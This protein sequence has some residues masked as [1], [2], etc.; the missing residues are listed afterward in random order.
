MLK[1][2]LEREA[3]ERLRFER[4]QNAPAGGGPAAAPRVRV[5]ADHSASERSLREQLARAEAVAVASEPV[6]FYDLKEVAARK[7]QELVAKEKQV[8]HYVAYTLERVDNSPI[9]ERR[10]RVMEFFFRPN[11]GTLHVFE[12]EQKNSGLY[13]VRWWSG[14]ALPEGILMD[15]RPHVLPPPP[16]PFPYSPSTHSGR[17]RK[18][19]HPLQG[20]RQRQ[21]LRAGGLCDRRR[22][23]RLGPR[24]HDRGR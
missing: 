22:D 4:T 12:P 20:R 10:T 9:E 13:Q 2:A 24:L 18:A 23:P 17:L 7:T 14:Q 11:D 8:L 21:R 5:A 6:H 19:P 3:R 15:T 16:S 1:K